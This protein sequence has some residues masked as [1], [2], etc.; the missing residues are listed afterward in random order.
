M[1]KISFVVLFVLP[2]L[3][4]LRAALIASLSHVSDK[5]TTPSTWDQEPTLKAT[6]TTLLEEQILPVEAV[7]ITL[8]AM[9]HT[10]VSNMLFSLFDVHAQIVLLLLSNTTFI[11]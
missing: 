6:T 10:T 9:D 8:T 4:S 1:Q 3:R 7:T 2:P 5:L 11:H